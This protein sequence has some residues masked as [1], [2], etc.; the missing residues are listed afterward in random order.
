MIKARHGH[1]GSK[2]FLPIVFGIAAN[3][4]IE[5][6]DMAKQMPGVKHSA[7]I[8]SGKEITFDEYCDI[9]KISAYKHMWRDQY[10]ERRSKL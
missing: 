9:R 1:V 5:A 4:L 3:D 8:L 7:M 6:M 2:K 10:K